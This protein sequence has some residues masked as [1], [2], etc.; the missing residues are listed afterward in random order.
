[1]ECVNPV[2]QGIT[3][4]NQINDG[5]HGKDES[6]AIIIHGDAAF[7]GQGVNYESLQMGGLKN[8][9]TGGDIHIIINN[10]VGFTASPRDG[11]S[12]IYCTD[13]AKAFDLPV[14]HVNADDPIAVEFSCRVAAE[15][16]K[17]FKKSIFIDIIGYR[18]HGH[19]ELDQPL[20]TQ[21]LVYKNMPKKEN[22]LKIYE[23]YLINQGT[24]TKVNYNLI[25]GRIREKKGKNYPWIRKKPRSF[26]ENSAFS[27]RE[28]S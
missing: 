19:N 1:M 23:Q 28:F 22:V 18:K 12:G 8:F 6:L 5:D 15:Y 3:Y 10:N 21:P 14:I 25:I 2:V 16:R 24:A 7:S 27:K 13:L 11:R 26:E 4:S 20:F 17:K 9:S